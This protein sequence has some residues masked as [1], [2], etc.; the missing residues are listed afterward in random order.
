MILFRHESVQHYS[1]YKSSTYLYNYIYMMKSHKWISTLLYAAGRL[2]QLLNM[3]A[4]IT[5][6]ENAVL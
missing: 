4:D 2:Y 5:T 1:K 3:R 6:L